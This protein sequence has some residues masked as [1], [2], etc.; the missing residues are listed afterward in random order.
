MESGD[1][2]ATQSVPWLLAGKAGGY[3]STGQCAASAGKSINDAMA[4]ICKALDVAP[5]PHY[6]TGLPGLKA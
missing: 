1:S 5:A 2:H 6:G 3:L 4:E